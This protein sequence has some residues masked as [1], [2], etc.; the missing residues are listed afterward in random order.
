M[1]ID[2]EHM[3]EMLLY[4]IE[5]KE[6][7]ADEVL[8]DFVNENY[9]NR[10][11]STVD[12]YTMFFFPGEENVLYLAGDKGLHRHVMNGSAVEQVIDGSLGSFADPGCNVLGMTMTKGNFWQS[13]FHFF[14]HGC[15]CG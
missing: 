10:N 7:V 3:D 1:V 13:G 6:Y 14:R 12:C 5:K 11:Y 2:G 15:A 8:V 4:D 9:K